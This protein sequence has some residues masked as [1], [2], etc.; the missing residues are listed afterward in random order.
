MQA[1]SHAWERV[2]LNSSSIASFIYHQLSR[3]KIVSELW[4]FRTCSYDSW[5]LVMR[6]HVILDRKGSVHSCIRQSLG[7]QYI[8]VGL[9]T[10]RCAVVWQPCTDRFVSEDIMYIR[11][12]PQVA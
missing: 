2:P 3:D 4:L 8:R 10:K 1:A 5:Q 7:E 12:P 9:D 11:L 6:W